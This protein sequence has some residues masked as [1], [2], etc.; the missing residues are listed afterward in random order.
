MKVFFKIINEDGEIVETIIPDCNTR[1]SRDKRVKR[2][3]LGILIG[4]S[5]CGIV[6]MCEELFGSEGISQV[7][8]ICCEY[9]SNL[10]FRNLKVLVYD[11][12]CHLVAFALKQKVRHQSVNRIFQPTEIRNF[13]VM[14]TCCT[15]DVC[16]KIF[17]SISDMLHHKK[18]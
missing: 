17:D 1:K 13:S 15:C 8:G 11:D 7:Y 2:H 3:T 16:K 4:A 9:L 18:E 10:F 14:K 12:V 5:P 6:R